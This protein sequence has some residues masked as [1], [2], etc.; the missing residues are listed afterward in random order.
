MRSVLISQ[1][2]FGVRWAL[3]YFFSPSYSVCLVGRAKT[4]PGLLSAFQLYWYPSLNPTPLKYKPSAPELQTGPSPS[5][6]PALCP[7]LDLSQECFLLQAGQIT[8]NHDH[9]VTDSA[10]SAA[11]PPPHWIPWI[12]SIFCL[13][14]QL[15]LGLFK[16]MNHAGK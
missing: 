1:L 14:A 10:V 12:Q 9:T 4:Q 11:T 6:G 16:W 3:R 2:L 5:S 8:W 7:S 13:F 15:L